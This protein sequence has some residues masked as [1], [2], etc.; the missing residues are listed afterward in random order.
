MWTFMM[1]LSPGDRT[2]LLFVPPRDGSGDPWIG[3]VG[4]E[5]DVGEAGVGLYAGRRLA[6]DENGE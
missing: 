6:E 3:L 1:K 2:E 4:V 5:V